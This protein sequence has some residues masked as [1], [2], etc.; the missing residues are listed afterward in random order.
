[1]LHFVSLSRRNGGKLIYFSFFIV[2]ALLLAGIST[3]VAQQTEQ[4]GKNIISRVIA[5]SGD[6]NLAL[7]IHGSMA[8]T[9]T[10]YELFKP[11]RIVV[12]VADAEV[13]SPQA[14]DLPEELGIALAAKSIQDVTPN[15]TRFEFTLPHSYSFT[16]R[17]QDNDII[18]TIEG[19]GKSKQDEV[20]GTGSS[21]AAAPVKQA[22]TAVPKQSIESQLPKVNPLQPAG[23]NVTTEATHA[24]VMEDSFNFSGYNKE[25]ITV[26]FYKID[27][28][29]VFRL[30]REVS[31][32]NIVVDE[33]VKGSLTLALNDVPW[34]FALDIILNLK[35]LTKEE[36][37]NT[38]VIHPKSKV[39][40]WPE[41][42]ED[43]LSFEAD[44]DVAEQEALI[45]QRQ[46][47]LPENVVD[48]K[49]LIA[50]GRKAE[51]RG[52]IET[53]V[54]LYEQAL[55]KWPKNDRLANKI[56][57]IYLVQLRQNAKAAYFADKALSVD[58]KNSS[59]ALNGAIAHANMQDNTIAQ[60]YFDQSISTGKPSSEALLSYAAFSEK[61]NHYDAAVK[62]LLKH[63]E[64][65]G[66]NLNSMVA[67]ARVLDKQGKHETATE[68][69]QA[70]LLAGFRVPPDLRKYITGRTTLNQTM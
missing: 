39:F 24:S 57:A 5:Q 62:L 21:V 51:K 34:D 17:Q 36:R 35:D 60:Q 11:S 38:I 6:N 8:P 63:D 18:I 13:K 31:G 23:T 47:V 28:H 27:L 66:Q 67:R 9:Y 2:T 1:M 16:T 10:I 37:F 64:I 54:Q 55:L 52:D 41:R 19:F 58:G 68:V 44:P 65:Y 56:A 7:K 14:L 33:S 29:N 4:G 59:A 12:D 45:I 53:A 40:D 43:N 15:L 49:K 26:D 42:A 30:L 46:E 61:L 32:V 3:S 25:R 20:Q 22:K 70:I 50:K 48:A 69:Y